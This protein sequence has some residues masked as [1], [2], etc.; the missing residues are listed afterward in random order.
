[1][2]TEQTWLDAALDD[3]EQAALDADWEEADSIRAALKEKVREKLGVMYFTARVT[4]LSGVP[5]TKAIEYGKREVKAKRLGP[6]RE[7]RDALMSEPAQQEVR[8]RE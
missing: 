5:W 8:D 6:W 2:G 4:A 7:L 1:M 3:F